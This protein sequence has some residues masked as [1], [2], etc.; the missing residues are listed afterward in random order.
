V[1]VVLV[2]RVRSSGEKIGLS[3]VRG[4]LD[5]RFDVDAAVSIACDEVSVAMTIGDWLGV[6]SVDV[7]VGLDVGE[8]VGLGLPD[9]KGRLTFR[10]DKKVGMT[11]LFNNFAA[12]LKCGITKAVKPIVTAT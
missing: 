10:Y 3:G 11:G 7:D 9:C 12:S 1:E 8:R 2:R 6:L 5:F 4:I